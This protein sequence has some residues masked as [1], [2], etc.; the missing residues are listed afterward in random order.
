MTL[1]IEVFATAVWKVRGVWVV[2]GNVKLFGF[3]K[4]RKAEKEVTGSIT[5]AGFNGGVN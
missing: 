4:H 3:Q 1:G 2:N 5:R